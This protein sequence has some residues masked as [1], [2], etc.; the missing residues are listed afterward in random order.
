MGV[1][2]LWELLAPVGRRVSVEA[3]GGRKLAIGWLCLSQLAFSV[4]SLMIVS[5]IAK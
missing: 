1:H 2:G 5:S 3:L 4:W